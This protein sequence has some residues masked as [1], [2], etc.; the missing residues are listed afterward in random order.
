MP[1]ID[2]AT[3]NRYWENAAPSILGPYMMDDFGFPVGAGEYRFKA[4]SQIVRRIIRDVKHDGTAL[5]L[6]SGV[7]YW[8]EE[9]SSSFSQV[10]AVEGSR[11][12]YVAL[13]QRCSAR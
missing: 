12:L 6:G 9:F 1:E 5:D 4:E 13:E 3:V 10:V 8:A 2:P 7:G 11:I